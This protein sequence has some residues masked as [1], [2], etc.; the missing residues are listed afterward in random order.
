[1]VQK[2]HWLTK[3]N[4]LDPPL[5][6]M[7]FLTILVTFFP[8][9]YEHQEQVDYF[10]DARKEIQVVYRFSLGLCYLLQEPL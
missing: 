9:L 6:I 1:M 4:H 5:R 2:L 10:L 7:T 3:M 8:F